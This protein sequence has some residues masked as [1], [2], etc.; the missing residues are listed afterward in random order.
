MLQLMRALHFSCRLGV[1]IN[2]W[3]VSVNG[4]SLLQVCNRHAAAFAADI[5]P[6]YFYEVLILQIAK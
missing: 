2:E 4:F 6:F 1:H 5:L 3:S